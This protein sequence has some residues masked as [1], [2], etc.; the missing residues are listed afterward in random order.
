MTLF[1][2]RIMQPLPF[3][4]LLSPQGEQYRPDMDLD[5]RVQICR[6]ME[7]DMRRFLNQ[8]RPHTK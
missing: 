5:S 2:V 7:L 4:F 3:E 1:A 8:P 6:R